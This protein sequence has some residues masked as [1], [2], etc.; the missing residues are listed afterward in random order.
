MFAGKNGEYSLARDVDEAFSRALADM[1]KPFVVDSKDDGLTQFQVQSR[2]TDNVVGLNDEELMKH[3]ASMLCCRSTTS[4]MYDLAD[5]IGELSGGLTSNDLRGI[6]QALSTSSPWGVASV[7]CDG[8]TSVTNDTKLTCSG[9]EA[10]CIPNG[11]VDYTHT[12]SLSSSSS[13]ADGVSSSFLSTPSG[14]THLA[15]VSAVTAT[16]QSAQVSS[17]PSCTV[18]AFGG[19]SLQRIYTSEASAVLSTP[20]DAGTSSLDS[21]LAPVMTAPMLQIGSFPSLP[22]VLVS[23][24]GSLLVSPPGPVSVPSARLPLLQTLPDV[25]TLMKPSRRY[26][27]DSQLAVTSGLAALPLA[28]IFTPFSTTFCPP[29]PVLSSSV[30]KMDHPL[31]SA[32]VPDTVSMASCSTSTVC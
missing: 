28:S 14:L 17:L 23:S 16:R 12:S 32:T 10:A 13:V 15:A 3:L 7:E 27:T 11:I 6:T 20:F 22:Q 21:L 19:T 5:S 24:Q 9:A 25:Q 29:P 2:L 18:A 30:T 4:P 8:M 1:S 26:V 31:A